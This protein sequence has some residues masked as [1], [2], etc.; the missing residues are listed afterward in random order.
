MSPYCRN[1]F[2]SKFCDSAY[3]FNQLFSDT[4]FSDEYTALSEVSISLSRAKLVER[5]CIRRVIENFI[6]SQLGN[7]NSGISGLLLY[8]LPENLAIVTRQPFLYQVV[9]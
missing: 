3:L 5:E 1:A 4:E 9:A 6:R 2:Q 7:L 8:E